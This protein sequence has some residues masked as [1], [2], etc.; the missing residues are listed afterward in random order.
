MLFR[1]NYWYGP[2]VFGELGTRYFMKDALGIAAG[3]H[4]YFRNSDMFHSAYYAQT[5]NVI[6]CIK[7]TKTTAEFDATAYPLI[8]YRSQFGTKPLT[9]TG[10]DEKLDAAAA[11]SEDGKFLTVGFVNAT[12]DSYDVTLNL[13]GLKPTGKADGWVIRHDNPL[14]HNNPGDT[15]ILGIVPLEPTDL[16]RTISIKPISITLFKVPLK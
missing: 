7:T 3:L 15:P 13:G 12:W 16:G 2:H 9:V 8:L 14:A 1:S 10:W 5:V 4:E 11:L 6:G